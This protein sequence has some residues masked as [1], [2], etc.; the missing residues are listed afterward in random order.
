MLKSKRILSVVAILAA[1]SLLLIGCGGGGGGSGA[2]NAATTQAATAATTKSEATT[3]ATTTAAPTTAESAA[4]PSGEMRKVTITFTAGAPAD[5]W[6]YCNEFKILKEKHNIEI[7]Y[8]FAD[9]DRFSLMLA[10]ND[11][12]GIISAPQKYLANII[13][14]KLALNLEPLLEEYAPSLLLDAYKA[15]ND[16]SK[17]YL[18]GP[19]HEL[20][21]IASNAGVEYVNSNDSNIRGYSV[22]WDLYKQI[23][24]PDINSDDD[25]ID[26]LRKMIELYPKTEEGLPVYGMGLIDDLPSWWTR[27]AFIRD[28]AVNL[29]TFSRYLY[30]A[31]WDDNVLYNGYTN[32]NRSAFWT[33]M[34]FYNKLFNAG[35]LDPD[36]FIMTWD[37]L[38]E[39]DKAGQY[40][41]GF[42]VSGT[43]YAEMRKKD[44]DT[45]VGKMM[46]PSTNA[47]IFSDFLLP[48]GQLPT[49]GC[50]IPAKDENWKAAMEV[51]NFFWDPDNLRITY[52]GIKGVD[53]DYDEDGVGYLTEKALAD[54]EKY[55]KGTAEYKKETGIYGG[56]NEFL[57]GLPPSSHPDGRS[58]EI[59][60]EFKYRAMVL[61]P[62]QKDYAAHYGYSCPSE[63][64]TYFINSGKTFGLINTAALT[65]AMGMTDIPM[66]LKRI[67]DACN[68][69]VY[70][71]IP[72]LVMAKT[73]GEFNDIQQR[74]LA[75]IAAQDEPKAWEWC[76]T[77]FNK[78]K[79]IVDPIYQEAKKIHLAK[80]AASQ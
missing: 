75:D 51:F 26:V 24:C 43:Q 37:S 47:V 66:D 48:N 65:Y 19:N 79:E 74:V 45:L 4:A 50:F 42:T 18:G 76:E 77:E 25:Y 5:T 20:Y 54:I 56:V 41:G 69:V 9:E 38:A 14:N 3:A 62:L 46:I 53:W 57:G 13:N 31:G 10:G 34:R 78:A 55:G 35:M 23:G 64:H 36:S 73:Q 60:Q 12:S 27:G 32:L 28:A 17:T 6:A 39:K 70:R 1:A 21:F 22:R 44:P 61:S 29:W 80:K 40:V 59:T 67:M 15:A 52:N 33:D 49:H 72:E 71:A 63:Y 16:L 2:T 58:Y 30:M 7:E 11:M 68:D 8:G